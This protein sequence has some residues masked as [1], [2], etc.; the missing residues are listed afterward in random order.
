MTDPVP[1]VLALDLG[2]ARI[3]LALSDPL[4]IAAH[5]IGS[6]PRTKAGGDARRIRELVNE[7][8][9]AT[10]V[11]GYPLH[12]SGRRGA[13]AVDA[14]HFVRRLRE[15]LP[16]IGVELWDERLTTAEVERLMIGDDVR[17]R[18]RRQVVDSLSAVVI[19]QSFLD[20]RSA[21]A[22]PPS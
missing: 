8:G 2:D 12:L 18:R 4:A 22:G 1:R 7:H 11:V 10:V 20:A 9:V 16:G 5:P 21:T 15:I 6:L 3:G 14:E 13:R 17:R 19:L